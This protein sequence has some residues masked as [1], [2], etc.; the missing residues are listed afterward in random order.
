[1]RTVRV[2]KACDTARLHTELEA[3]GV[4]VVTVRG[5]HERFPGPAWYAVVVLSDVTTPQ[6]EIAARALIAAHVEARV[7][8]LSRTANQKENDFRAMEIL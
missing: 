7:P 6:Q 4:P 2:D 1:M 5:Q 8:S 3:T